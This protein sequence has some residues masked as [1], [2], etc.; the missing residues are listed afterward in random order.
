MIKAYSG[1]TDAHKLPQKRVLEISKLLQKYIPQKALSVIN[2]GGTPADYM[3]LKNE[4]NIK[5]YT[6]LNPGL[7]EAGEGY[8]VIN[9]G[10][11]DYQPN[12][13]T[14]DVIFMLGTINH[15]SE[16]LDA[17]SKISK[18]MNSNSLFVFDYKDP[19]SKMKSMS[20]PV[21]SLQI[22]HPTYPTLKTLSTLHNLLKLHIKCV[23]THNKKLYTFILSKRQESNQNIPFNLNEYSEITHLS[24]K[25]L[26]LPKKILLKSIINYF[27][28][29]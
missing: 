16:P 11:E 12:G 22:D 28:F 7:D 15:L 5:D 20:H 13:R 17:F 29:I 6:C 8:V 18:L 19:L 3:F 25:A 27:N 9:S 2:I 26:K 21:G 1:K 23:K 14:F 4:I 24:K 10:I